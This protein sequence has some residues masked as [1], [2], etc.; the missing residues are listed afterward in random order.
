[1]KILYFVLFLCLIGLGLYFYLRR[2]LI[3]KL[4]T[5]APRYI[6]RVGSK[7]RIVCAGDS[8]THGNMGYNW[9]NDLQKE[10]TDFQVVNAGI[11]A[12]LAISLQRRLDEIIELEPSYITILI[13]TNDVN[14]SMSDKNFKRYVDNGKVKPT[15]V[16]SVEGFER[17]LEQIVN[18]LKLK[19]K[20]KIALIS[21]PLIGEDLLHEVNQTADR[22]SKL[23]FDT[24]KR[25][26]VDFLD[27]RSL[28]K[29]NLT[30]SKDQPAYENYFLLMQKSLVK[31]YYLRQS[32]D[33][34]SRN[35]GT[36]LTHDLL[37]Q[38]KKSATLLRSLVSDWIDSLK[39]EVKE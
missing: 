22:Y 24:S 36:E 16:I 12:D 9:V 23:I 17:V 6:S 26:D 39:R 4:P 11:N 2:V 32:W 14:A 8:N 27:F 35:H 31:Y 19:T 1:M 30:S 3:A 33:K 38:N 10:K 20:A 5:N 21:L 37:H 29:K 18:D 7:P 34:I 13:G 28:L 15:D 25:L